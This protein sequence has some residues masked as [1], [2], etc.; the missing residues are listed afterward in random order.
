MFGPNHVRTRESAGVTA[1]AL[2]ASGY[3]EEAA[4]L[5]EKYGDHRSK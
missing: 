5:R 4:A 2:D 1:D 3:V